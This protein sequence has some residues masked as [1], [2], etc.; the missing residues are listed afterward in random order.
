MTEVKV[1]LPQ[2]LRL[3]FCPHLSLCSLFKA[4]SGGMRREREN[5]KE[6]KW[7][8]SSNWGSVMVSIDFYQ[9]Y[10]NHHCQLLY[11]SSLLPPVPSLLLSPVYSPAFLLSPET[12]LVHRLSSFALC[13]LLL[14]HLFTCPNL[15]LCMCPPLGFIPP[16]PVSSPFLLSS[17][18]SD[19]S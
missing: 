10:A 5:I 12:S 8:H 7:C 6:G 18:T 9:L 11:L 16:H 15:S 17:Q 19:I 14:H 13:L 1:G 2:E 4:D 3:H